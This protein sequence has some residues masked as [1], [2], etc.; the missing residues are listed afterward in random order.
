LTGR[1]KDFYVTKPI[2]LSLRDFYLN[3]DQK[4]YNRHLED[5]R[6]GAS[7]V[8]TMKVDAEYNIRKEERLKL[9]QGLKNKGF[10][11]YEISE[12]TRLTS[13]EIDEF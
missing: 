6:Y 4:N 12:L 8:W 7:M 3:E 10:G 9:A 5:L 1:L 13:D 2:I 11:N